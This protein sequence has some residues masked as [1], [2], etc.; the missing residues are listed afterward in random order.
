MSTHTAGSD[1]TSPPAQHPATTD[2]HEFV[3]ALDGGQ[4]ERK[5]SVALALVPA[6]V[7]DTDGK[8]EVS[9][10]LKFER[11]AGTFQIRVQ[12][13][14]RFSRPTLDGAASEHE[15]RSTVLW[16]GKH[17]RLSLLPPDVLRGGQTTIPNT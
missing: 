3:D 12:H 8:G 13:E 6:A 14:L 16:V 7:M 11:M 10:K 17:G 5:L 2:V 1:P 4:F 9:I 15:R